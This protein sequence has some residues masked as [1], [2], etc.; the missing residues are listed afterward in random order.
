MSKRSFSCY[1]GEGIGVVNIRRVDAMQDHVHD[2]DDIGERL[3]F[4]AGERCPGW[5][6]RAAG[7]S[8]RL[9]QFL[10]PTLQPWPSC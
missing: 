8:P 5:R 7:P 10:Q 6:A 9:L 1:V 3:L 2:A 4:L